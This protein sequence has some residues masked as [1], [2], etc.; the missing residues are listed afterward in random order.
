MSKGAP[1]AGQSAHSYIL[2]RNSTLG[3]TLKDSLQEMVDSDQ[4]DS[5]TALK[6]LHEFDRCV[7]RALREDVD[8]KVTLSGGL[9]TYRLCDNVWTM[10]IENALVRMDLEAIHC[11]MLKIVAC[12][13]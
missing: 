5:D 3:E 4:I 8:S 1:A 7:N 12:D 9:H 11:D 10:Y 13:R 2:Y 6:I